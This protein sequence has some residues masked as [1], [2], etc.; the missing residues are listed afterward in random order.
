[1]SKATRRDVLK[2]AAAAG[3]AGMV[4]CNPQKQPS[5]TARFLYKKTKCPPG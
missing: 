2:G 3:L 5:P 4:G 1:M